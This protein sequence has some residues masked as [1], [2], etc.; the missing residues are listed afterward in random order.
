VTPFID[1]LAEHGFDLYQDLDGLYKVR[2]ERCWMGCK[3]SPF[4]VIHFYYWAEEFAKG[5]P[6][7]PDNCLCWDSVKLN[8]PGD[9]DYDPTRP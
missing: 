6:M 8:L 9:V 2:W 3:P 7:D 1:L 4:F 5:K